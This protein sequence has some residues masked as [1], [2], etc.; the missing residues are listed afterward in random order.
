MGGEDFVT[1]G[2][3]FAKRFPQRVSPRCPLL[4]IVCFSESWRRLKPV[5]FPT[6]VLDN[7]FWSSALGRKALR[8]YRHFGV[9][10]YAGHVNGSSMRG[11]AKQRKF[12]WKEICSR[13]WAVWRTREGRPRCRGV[14]SPAQRK[15][16]G[17]CGSISRGLT[18]KRLVI[19]RLPSSCSWQELR[20]QRTYWMRSKAETEARQALPR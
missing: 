17:R 10:D 3:F 1:P 19:S 4:V 18:K 14:E 2:V 13:V 11:S 6:P 20:W 12:D 5:Y 9:P 7:L 15:P 16:L 8:G